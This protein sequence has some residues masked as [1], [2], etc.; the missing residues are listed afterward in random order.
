MFPQTGEDVAVYVSSLGRVIPHPRA[1]DVKRL[2][3]L[4]CMRRHPRTLECGQ[5]QQPMPLSA[6]RDSAFKAPA[7]S[8]EMVFPNGCG[9]M[10][11]HRDFSS[12]VP[13]LCRTLIISLVYNVTLRRP[14]VVRRVWISSLYSRHDA[15]DD[16]LLFL[17]HF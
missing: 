16:A 17:S 14:H 2:N 1:I 11:A 6:V 5:P 15:G 9:F 8:S 3:R 7:P 12:E 13:D 10:L 4:R